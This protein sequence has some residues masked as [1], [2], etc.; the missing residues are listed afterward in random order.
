MEKELALRYI[1]LIKQKANPYCIDEKEQPNFWE[2]VLELCQNGNADIS[3]LLKGNPNEDQYC[4]TFV[5]SSVHYGVN[6][7]SDYSAH[8]VIELVYKIVDEII[9]WDSMSLDDIKLM[10]LSINYVELKRVKKEFQPMK[11]AYYHSLKRR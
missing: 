8:T 4:V 11:S 6:H 3:S 9:N 5:D 2:A 7:F 10:L 1:R